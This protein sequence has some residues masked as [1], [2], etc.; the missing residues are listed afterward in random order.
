MTIGWQEI[1]ALG[2]VGLAAF[3]LIR[4][5][6]GRRSDSSCCEGSCAGPETLSDRG[7][8]ITELHQVQIE[9]QLPGT[10]DREG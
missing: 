8:K 9:H 6:L 7:V 4:R 10:E 2:I 1:I 3:I 5:V